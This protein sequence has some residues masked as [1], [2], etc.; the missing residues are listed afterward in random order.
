[1]MRSVTEICFLS[2]ICR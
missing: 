1:M 2:K